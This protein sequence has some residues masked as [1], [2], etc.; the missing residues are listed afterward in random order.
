M[1]L[2]RK[3]YEEQ[4]KSKK[5]SESAE[6]TRRPENAQ[7]KLLDA[8]LTNSERA[9]FISEND[10]VYSHDTDSAHKE[11]GLSE[12]DYRDTGSEDAKLPTLL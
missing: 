1:T 2:V 7:E 5:D 8:P 11:D 3:R 6:H 10:T 12:S 4:V 9:V